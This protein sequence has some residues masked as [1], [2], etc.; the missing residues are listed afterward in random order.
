MAKKQK[1]GKSLVA[2]EIGL[3]AASVAALAGGYLLYGAQNANKNR[4]KVKGW[5]LKAKGEILEKIEGMQEVTEDKYQNVVKA[6]SKKYSGLK[7]V[8]ASDLA[9]LTKETKKHWQAIQKH[10]VGSKKPAQKS[11]SKKIAKKAKR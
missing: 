8:D 4:K 5:M 11:P 2:A 9:N 3:A 1:M 7:Q 6:V 10:L